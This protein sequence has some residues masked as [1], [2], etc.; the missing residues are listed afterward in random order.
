MI[1]CGTAYPSIIG[2]MIISLLRYQ[3]RPTASCLLASSLSYLTLIVCPASLNLVGI[4][5]YYLLEAQSFAPIAW[6]ITFLILYAPI[7]APADPR[8]VINT[9]VITS[10]PPYIYDVPRPTVTAITGLAHALNSSGIN[11]F[12]ISTIVRTMGAICNI[13]MDPPLL[14]L[15]PDKS[16]LY[17]Y[18]F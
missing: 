14:F 2:C 5:R 15:L 9:S 18:D 13:V 17:L 16:D 1:S 7:A 10:D 12:T 3:A 11:L 8:P 6:P 4:F